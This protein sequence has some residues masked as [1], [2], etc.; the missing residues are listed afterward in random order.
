MTQEL[1]RQGTQTLNY[2]NMYG[3][4]KNLPQK[5]TTRSSTQRIA[6]SNQSYRRN[7][8]FK[9]YSSQGTRSQ[10]Q[11]RSTNSKQVRRQAQDYIVDGRYSNNALQKVNNSKFKEMDFSKGPM[12]TIQPGE[13]VKTGIK[14]N[15][16][17]IAFVNLSN[18]P[19]Y[20]QRK[21]NKRTGEYNHV[22]FVQRKKPKEGA[23]TTNDKH[24]RTEKLSFSGV[25]DEKNVIGNSTSFIL[26]VHGS[27]PFRNYKSAS[28][29]V[30]RID[31]VD[32]SNGEKLEH[33]KAGTSE[34]INMN[35]KQVTVENIGDRDISVFNRKKQDGTSDYYVRTAKKDENIK[36]SDLDRENSKV[37][38]NDK[39]S[40]SSD[41][42]KVIDE[43]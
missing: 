30:Q 3:N 13:K 7:D 42:V 35:G 29:P 33:V 4:G 21:F 23:K 9:R 31:R 10:V 24:F 34:K 18:K 26:N 39:A 16:S 43:N 8:S 19:A 22:L 32:L 12:I 6:R 1:Y 40:F 38:I 5:Q 25:R 15:S 11:S 17:E 36:I 14:N 41:M 20:I 37:V 27:V 2:S 28:S